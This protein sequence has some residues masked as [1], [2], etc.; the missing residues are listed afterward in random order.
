MNPIDE[1]TVSSLLSVVDQ[2]LSKGLGSP[3]P[4]HMCVEAAVCYSLGLPH[5]DDPLCV[6]PSLRKLKIKINDAE[7]YSKH[8]RAK[9]LRRLA[10]AQLGTN[11]TLN[12]QEFVKRV[13]I[14]LVK[15][16]LANIVKDEELKNQ[17]I[18]VET[19]EQ[20][21][22]AATAVYYDKTII[23][24]NFAFRVAH[25]AY[26]AVLYIIKAKAE[27]NLSVTHVIHA[28]ISSTLLHNVLEK[29]KALSDF[30]ENVVQILIDMKSPGCEYLYLTEK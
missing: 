12:E 26:F 13:V 6:A 3:V 20:A 10:V 1:S 24:D 9:G 16:T 8:T 17:C 23:K 27:F 7:W 4:G 28:V 29:D 21:K 22:K 11:E 19:L 15:T 18:A 14:M 5:S 25:S 30:C 2:G